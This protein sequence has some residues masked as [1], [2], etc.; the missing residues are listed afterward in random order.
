MKLDPND[1][2]LDGISD[3]SSSDEEIHNPDYVRDYMLSK[4]GASCPISDI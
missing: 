3:V 2:R 1:D 4:S